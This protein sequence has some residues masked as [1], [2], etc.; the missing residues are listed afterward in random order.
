[1]WKGLR[2]GR[3]GHTTQQQHAAPCRRSITSKLA[4]V[5]SSFF[6]QRL[7]L[8]AFGNFALLSLRMVHPGSDGLHTCCSVLFLFPFLV[9]LDAFK[10]PDSQGCLLGAILLSAVLINSRCPGMKILMLTLALLWPPKSRNGR[11]CL[12]GHLV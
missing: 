12:W 4:S 9:L 7:T 6:R 8:K 1:M 11:C 10:Y 5:T 3:D 2:M